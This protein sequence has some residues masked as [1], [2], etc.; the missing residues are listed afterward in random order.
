METHETQGDYWGLIRFIETAG[1]SSD[2]GRLME[3]YENSGD[4]WGLMRLKET[5]GDS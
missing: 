3:S 5:A 1:D 4:F 2:S